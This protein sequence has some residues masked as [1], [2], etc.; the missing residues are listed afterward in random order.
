MAKYLC[1]FSGWERSLRIGGVLG[2][3]FV[4]PWGLL[5]I[6]NM[7]GLE[8]LAWLTTPLMMPGAV[9]LL[10]PLPERVGW[11]LALSLDWA[12]YSLMF[13]GL[14]HAFRGLVADV[15]ATRS[16]TKR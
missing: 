4:L 9:T 1:D 5:T 2:F 12:L 16:V 7:H 3:L 15:R 10:L 11:F 13:G 6:F 14:I 8:M